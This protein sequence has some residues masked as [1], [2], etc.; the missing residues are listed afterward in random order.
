MI[1]TYQPASDVSQHARIDLDQVDFETRLT[2]FEYTGAASG[3]TIYEEGGHSGG[4]VELTVGALVADVAKGSVV[5]Q[6]SGGALGT[7]K[8]DAAAGETSLVVSVSGTDCVKGGAVTQVTTGWGVTGT[9]TDIG[10]ATAAVYTY[11]TMQGFST[12]AKSK[13]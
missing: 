6:A 9:E 8:S 13:M 10:S 1:A 4:K 11:R 7:V 2:A 3:T 5:K 12:A